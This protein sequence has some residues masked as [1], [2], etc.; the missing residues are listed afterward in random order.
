MCLLS[1]RNFDIDINDKKIEEFK[2]KL[3]EYNIKYDNLLCCL[4]EQHVVGYTR[5]GENFIFF[6]SEIGVKYPDLS[7]ELIE[8]KESFV[9]DFIEYKNKL[10]KIIEYKNSD[11]FKKKIMCKLCNFNVKDD[12]IEF[13]R[14]LESPEHQYRLKELRK[15][16]A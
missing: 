2:S 4:R 11:E 3:N 15:E 5:N 1:R 16:F 13:K 8:N 9:N 10:K 6:G 7:F 14:H 12:M